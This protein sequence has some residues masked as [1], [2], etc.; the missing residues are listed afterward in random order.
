MSKEIIKLKNKYE[1]IKMKY[2]KQNKNKKI[3]LNKKEEL[4]TLRKENEEL[5]K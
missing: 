4:T 1:S 3:L 2:Q 5:E